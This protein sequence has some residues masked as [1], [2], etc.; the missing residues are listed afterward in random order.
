VQIPFNGWTDTQ[1]VTSAWLLAYMQS[2]VV[3]VVGLLMYVVYAARKV[4]QSDR[5]G[6]AVG[7]AVLTGIVIISI[8]EAGLMSIAELGV[9][10][11]A[12]VYWAESRA[13]RE[14]SFCEDDGR[15]APNALSG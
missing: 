3:G 11:L 8:T 7:T 15:S 4:R 10:L 6:R 2:G 12:F 14:D 5:I 1:T 13:C 9:T